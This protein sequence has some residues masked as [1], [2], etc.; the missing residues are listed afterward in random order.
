M[1][2][3]ELAGLIL[4]VLFFQPAAAWSDA[5]LLIHPTLIMFE[6]NQRSATITLTN[7]G[8]ETGTFETGWIEY[9][10]SPEGGLRKLDEAAPWSVQPYVRY[11]PRRVTLEPAASQVIKVALRRRKDVAQGEYYSHFRVLTLNSE[12]PAI[13]EAGASSETP[14]TAASVLIKA[15]TAVAIPIIWRNS[16]E[17]SG[18]TIQAAKFDRETRKLTVTVQRSGSLSVRGFLFV[19]DAATD[20]SRDPLANPVPLV[21]YP[22]LD[23]RTI[24]ITLREEVSL[25]SLA[26]GVTVVYSPE[27]EA[28][29]P[30]T[31][32]ASYPVTL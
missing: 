17:T 3:S 19:F 23:R 7:R 20:G 29:D 24:D 21:I 10:M 12:D 15:R 14:D 6:G 27:L 5:V 18:A 32:I 11:S 2:N 4:A 13:G 26:Q 31:I 25:D 16:Q 9:E 30:A 28:I 22:N 8:D 1:K